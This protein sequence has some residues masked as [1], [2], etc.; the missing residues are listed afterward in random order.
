MP[1]QDWIHSDRFAAWARAVDAVPLPE[2]VLERL[3]E[4]GRPDDDV[5]AHRLEQSLRRRIAAHHRPG[6]DETELV[7]LVCR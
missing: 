4:Q 3:M 1:G 5:A 7:R 6:M 2:R